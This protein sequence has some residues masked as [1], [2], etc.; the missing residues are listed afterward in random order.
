MPPAHLVMGTVIITRSHLCIFNESST[1]IESA[2]SGMGDSSVENAPK[3]VRN[4]RKNKE[5]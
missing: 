5:M 1:F 4:L 2:W 3:S